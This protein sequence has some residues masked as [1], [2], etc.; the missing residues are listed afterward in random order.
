MTHFASGQS[1]SNSE[2]TIKLDGMLRR[3]LARVPKSWMYDMC[4]L[5]QNTQGEMALFTTISVQDVKCYERRKR[6]IKTR[7]WCKAGLEYGYCSEIN[8]LPDTPA[9]RHPLF[10][11][12]TFILPKQVVRVLNYV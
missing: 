1:T 12:P 11:V 3:R 7:G 8:E 4:Q 2:F 9:F 5:Y 10:E 6:C